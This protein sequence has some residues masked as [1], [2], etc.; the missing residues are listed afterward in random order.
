DSG[1]GCSG[2]P[3][4]AASRSVAVGAGFLELFGVLLVVLADPFGGAKVGVLA[5]VRA[6][7]AGRRRAAEGLGHRA[8][9]VGGAAAA[10]AEVVDAERRRRRRERGHVVAGGQERVKRG[11]EGPPVRGLFVT[12][13]GERL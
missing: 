5:H 6:K 1:P 10:D 7:P 9:V 4:W 2:W 8:D 12:W 11:R 13:V 3:R